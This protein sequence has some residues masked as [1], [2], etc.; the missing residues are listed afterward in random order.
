MNLIGMVTLLAAI[1]LEVCGQLCMKRAMHEPVKGFIAALGRVYA[2]HWL[3][4][5]IA[6][7]VIEA[8][9]WTWTLYLLP[10]NIA[11]P[12]GSLCFA[13]VAVGAA[14][15]LHEPVS[16]VRWLGIAMILLGVGLLGMR[17]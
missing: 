11:F 3:Q 17:V 10:L 16:R 7:F 1:S 4:A 12:M 14:Y 6:A 15:F 2:D 13:G 9:F 5:G 8:I